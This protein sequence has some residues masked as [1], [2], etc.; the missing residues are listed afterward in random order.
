M[1]NDPP[2]AT[3]NHFAADLGIPS[4]SD[5]LRIGITHRISPHLSSPEIFGSRIV[6]REPLRSSRAMARGEITGKKPTQTTDQTKRLPGP[7]SAVSA[8]IEP[9]VK[10]EP[11]APAK[12]KA[13]PIRGPPTPAAWYTI[14]TFCE[15][16]KLSQAM[17]FKLKA[18]KRG[19]RET[20]VGSRRYISFEDA[21]AW[22]AAQKEAVAA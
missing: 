10:S 20:A 16:H 21:A 4:E 9:T 14:R 3:L 6:I 13:T 19:P 12:A 7:P 1:A 17:Y 2:F 11:D 5:L 15:A 8:A 22:R 18:D